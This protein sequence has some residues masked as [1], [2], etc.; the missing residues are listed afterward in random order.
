MPSGTPVK[1]KKLG[2]IVFTVS[3][4]TNLS[5]TFGVAIVAN[6]H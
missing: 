1:V 3:A 6:R 5:E 2:H 4:G